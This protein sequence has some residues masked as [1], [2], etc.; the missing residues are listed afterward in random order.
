MPSTA[1]LLPT[2]GE[3]YERKCIELGII[4]REPPVRW[5]RI[6]RFFRLSGQRTEGPAAVIPRMRLNSYVFSI[7]WAQFRLFQTR[8]F[9]GKETA[10][11]NFRRRGFGLK[12]ASNG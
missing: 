7:I 12:S 2:P 10:I 3:D 9:R 1:R 6:L 11:P 4:R 5:D 8:R